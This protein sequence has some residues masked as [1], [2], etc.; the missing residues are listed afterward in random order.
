MN[1]SHHPAEPAPAPGPSLDSLRPDTARRWAVLAGTI[2]TLAALGVVLVPIWRRHA[3]IARVHAGLPSLPDISGMPVLLAER[4]KNAQAQAMS[5]T[6]ALDGVAELGRLYHA[7]SYLREAEA[8]WRL[9]RTEQPREAHWSYYLADSRRSAA[10]YTEM[11]AL[12]AE[13]VRLAPDFA[14][15]WLQL[16]DYQLKTGRI[17]E[18]GR[19]YQRRLALRP[20]DIYGRLGLTR[21]ALLQGRRD[22]ARTLLEQLVKDAPEFS[23]AHNLY[24]EMLTE[25]GDRARASLQR[26]LGRETTR[27]RQAEDPWLDGLQDRCFDFERLCVLASIEYQ[28]HHRDRAQAFYERAIKVRPDDGAGY[29]QLGDMFLRLGEA[30][31]ARDLLEQALQHE[32]GAKPSGIWYV[33]LSHAYRDLKQPAEAVRVAR[34]GLAQVGDDFELYDALGIALGD[35]GQHEEAVAALQAAVT[36]NPDDA[37]ANYNLAVAL[38]AVRR[39]D[40]AIAALH[41]SLVLKPTFPD[42]LALL[43]RIEMDSGRWQSA[44]KYLQPLYESHPEMPLAKQLMAD[45]HLRA[46]LDAQAKNDLGAAERHYRDGAIIAPNNPEAQANLGTLYLVQGRFADAVSPLEAYHRLQPQDPQSSLFLGQAYAA[47]GRREDARRLLTEGLE[48]ATRAGN[49]TTAQHCQEILDQL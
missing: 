13:T 32:K 45:W 11:A 4:L 2:L 26:L 6:G 36:R 43:T 10:D 21:I 8:C 47:T 12:L 30:G 24:A 29:A 14:P 35:S 46:G 48:T 1:W 31:K 38:L 41:R 42:T 27:F 37:N 9:L 16:A 7:N 15:A 40:D 23:T 18:A 5:P 44:A 3:L 22:E 28:T 17:E 25:D 19:D 20:G 49:T 33:D 34:L 39:L